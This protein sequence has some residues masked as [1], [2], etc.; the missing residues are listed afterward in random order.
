[1]NKEDKLFSNGFT[2][3]LMQMGFKKA[4]YNLPDREF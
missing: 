4:H 1:M 2:A 3:K